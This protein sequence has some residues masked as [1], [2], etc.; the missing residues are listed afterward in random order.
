MEKMG[1]T[2][3]KRSFNNGDE[4]T[5]VQYE[6]GNKDYFVCSR[7][8]HHRLIAQFQELLKKREIEDF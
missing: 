5:F 1:V 6:N 3:I 7:G 2:L 4:V 8:I